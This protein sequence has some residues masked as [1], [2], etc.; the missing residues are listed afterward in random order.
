M[1]MDEQTLEELKEELQKAGAKT[2]QVRVQSCLMRASRRG[3]VPPPPPAPPLC[4]CTPAIA[5]VDT[6]FGTCHGR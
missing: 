1:E 6:R 3:G 2:A 5:E 4:T